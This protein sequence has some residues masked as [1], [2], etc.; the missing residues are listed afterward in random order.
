MKLLIF[1]LGGEMISSFDVQNG[2][3]GSN[4]KP[5]SGFMLNTAPQVDL[6]S[7]FSHKY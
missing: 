6:I 5:C 1:S 3:L 4:F 2:V 7:F